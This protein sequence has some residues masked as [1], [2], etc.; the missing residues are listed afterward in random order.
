M[1][2]PKRKLEPSGR[3][4]TGSKIYIIACTASR[5]DARRHVSARI[6]A[7]NDDEAIRK[8]NVIVKRSGDTKYYRYTL[9]DGL[10]RKVSDYNNIK[11]GLINE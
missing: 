11:G 2:N 4:P 5:K 7:A 8:F 9:Y 1:K 3:A 10:W 6:T